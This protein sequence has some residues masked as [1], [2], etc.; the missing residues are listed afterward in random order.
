MQVTKDGQ[1]QI[2]VEIGGVRVHMGIEAGSGLSAIW[3]SATAAL[4]LQPKRITAR[5]RLNAGGI[6]L[7]ETVNIDGL[8]IGN[9]R[10]SSVE[11]LVY[12]RNKYFPQSLGEDDV[13][14][15]LGQD[16]FSKLDVELDFGAHQLRLYS[17]Q[18]CPGAVVYWSGQYDVLPLQKGKLGN[19]SMAMAVNGRLVSTSM[20]TM[21]PI[22]TIEEEAAKRILGIDRL[23]S[24]G[25]AGGGGDGCSY[26]RSITLKAQGLEIRNA[27]VT[28]VNSVSKSC[29]LN[30]PRSESGI[31]SYDCLG[32]FPLHLGVN[33][34]STL[35]LFYANGEKKL[36]FTNAGAKV[37]NAGTQPTPP[38]ATTE[39]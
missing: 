39:P 5:G 7:T 18:H 30:L 26:C 2:P 31:A 25:D 23:S 17:Q 33:V 15:Y 32:A 36:Y 27:R 24:S 10:W 4:G 37:L 20:S 11:V 6:P 12:P 38:A 28:I 29:Q 13:V 1:V 8:K 19:L 3:S 35:H 9:V 22:S 16:L 34:L 21:S 14:G